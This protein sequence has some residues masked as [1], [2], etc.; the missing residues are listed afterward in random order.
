MDSSTTTKVD[1]VN[2]ILKLLA[3]FGSIGFGTLTFGIDGS[4]S[5][6]GMCGAVGERRRKLN[7]KIKEI[8]K[9]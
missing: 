4:G 9:N 8:V 7:L 6:L 5:I 1:N 2:E 3:A